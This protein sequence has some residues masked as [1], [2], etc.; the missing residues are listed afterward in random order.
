MTADE[1]IKYF[2]MKPLPDEGGYYIETYRSSEKISGLP[3]RYD[4]PRNFSTAILYLITPT[5]FSKLHRVKSDEIF[6]F[7]LGDAVEMLKI[8]DNGKIK[9]E[10]LGTDI[11]KNQKPQVVVEKNIWQGTKLTPGGKFALLGCTVA[12]GFEFSDYESGSKEKR[13]QQFPPHLKKYIENYT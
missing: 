2:N 11:L 3:N 7:Y 5:S 6:H 4:G 9:I 8:S 12:P 1:L 13:I 10:I